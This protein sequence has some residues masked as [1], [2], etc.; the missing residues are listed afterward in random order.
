MTTTRKRHLKSKFALIQASSILFH[1]IW[2]C[3][4]LAKLYGV[5][6]ERTLSQFGKK[7]RKFLCW[8][9]QLHKAGPWN[10]EVSSRR[11]ATTAKKCTKSVSLGASVLPW[12]VCADIVVVKSFGGK[13]AT[14]S[15]G[16]YRGLKF[17]PM[18]ANMKT[19]LESKIVCNSHKQAV[20]LTLY[21][22]ICSRTTWCT[23]KVVALLM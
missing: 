20:L 8:V 17:S 11:L 4:I 22:D 10:Y 2:I 14:C 12:E 13:F 18:G 9:H 23:C 21:Y 6:S 19:R 16:N 1:F 5:E 15:D 7:K 3:K